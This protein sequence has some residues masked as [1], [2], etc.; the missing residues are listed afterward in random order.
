GGGRGARKGAR[1]GPIADRRRFTSLPAVSRAIRRAHFI[2]W[3]TPAACPETRTVD[4]DAAGGIDG[5]LKV[6]QG[7]PRAELPGV[8]GLEREEGERPQ[9]QEGSGRQGGRGRS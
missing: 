9:G 1:D 7:L 8:P 3:T 6:L 5:E 4:V 2:G